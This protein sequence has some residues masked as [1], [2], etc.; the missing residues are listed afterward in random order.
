MNFQVFL[1][2]C[3]KNYC[4]S[5]MSPVVSRK[6]LERIKKYLRGPLTDPFECDVALL[7]SALTEA[8]RG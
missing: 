7:D 5:H 3:D 6:K 4:I 1:K 8:K 2:F